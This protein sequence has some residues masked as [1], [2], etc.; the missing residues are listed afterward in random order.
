MLTWGLVNILPLYAGGPY[1]SRGS[2]LR[3]ER[4]LGHGEF[5]LGS[6]SRS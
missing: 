3:Q 5:K 2:C 1:S 6:E 4:R